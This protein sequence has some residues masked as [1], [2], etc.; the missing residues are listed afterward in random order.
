M[1]SPAGSI[2]IS[3]STGSGQRPRGDQLRLQIAE[4]GAR[5]QPAVPQQVADLFEGRVP[6][7][8]VDVVAAVGQHA[9]IAVE[10]ADRRRGGD[11]IFEPR[12]G[13]RGRVH[14]RNH[15]SAIADG[16]RTASAVDA[17]DVAITCGVATCMAALMHAGRRASAAPQPP[18]GVG[19][20]CGPICA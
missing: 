2:R 3:R 18:A 9:A 5:R 16:L 13:L 19:A 12:F 17:C 11:G 7:E 8:I 10:I 15:S 6:R 4:L 1:P 20:P 14:S